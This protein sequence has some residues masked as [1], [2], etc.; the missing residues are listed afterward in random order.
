MLKTRAW[1]SDRAENQLATEDDLVL[2]ESAARNVDAARAAIYSRYAD[3]VYRYCHSIL[4]NSHDARDAMQSAMVKGLWG[5]RGRTVE[6]RPW[7]LQIA[8]NVSIDMIRMRGR[9]IEL[10]QAQ[11]SADEGNDGPDRRRRIDQLFSDLGDLSDRQREALVMR[12]LGGLGYEE[13]ARLLGCNEPAARRSVFRARQ[14]LASVTAGRQA[15]CGEIRSQ[16]GEDAPQLEQAIATRAHL[17]ECHECR[18]WVT[19]AQ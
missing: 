1:L 16:L 8:H 13:I 15:E 5:L 4:G 17:R 6:L 11:E 12:E 19:T 10:E 9:R 14:R 2:A 7:L 18:A 3:L